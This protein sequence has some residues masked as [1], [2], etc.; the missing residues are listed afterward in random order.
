MNDPTL[1][2]PCEYFG[3]EGR[4][5]CERLL[6]QHYDGH[7]CIDYRCI[8][9]A[10][11]DASSSPQSSVPGIDAGGG[12]MT[13]YDAGVMVADTG[14]PQ[15]RRDSDCDEGEICQSGYC[16]PSGVPPRRDTGA[17]TDSG[18]PNMDTG[19]VANPGA[20]DSGPGGC[21]RDDDC[22]WGEICEDGRCLPSGLPP[23]PDAGF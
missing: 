14:G 11:P 20:M 15:C 2:P 21:S 7:Q 16:L 19:L 18:P 4:A 12:G 8:R 10:Q 6:Q 1:S 9:P 23:V 3:A 5:E 22:D 13:V 17:V